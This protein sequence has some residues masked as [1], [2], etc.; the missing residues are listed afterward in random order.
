MT[1]Q[2]VLDL[3]EKTI[4]VAA[5]ASAPMLVTSII[6]G[7]VINII[8]TVTQ[9]RDTSLSFVPKVAA[10]AVVTVITLPW[11]LNIQIEFCVTIFRMM[12]EVN[13]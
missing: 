3:T 8:Q 1:I 10:A 6:V 5:I 12:G 9:I 2:T 4:S 11:A 13:R 7:V